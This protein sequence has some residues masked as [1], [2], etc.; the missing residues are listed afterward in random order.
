[1][2]E[3]VIAMAIAAVVISMIMFFISV[4]AKSFRRT[5]DDVNLQMEAQTTINQISNLAMEAKAVDIWNGT[6]D[7]RYTFQYNDTEFKTI[8]LVSDEKKLYQVSTTGFEDAKTVS[9]NMQQNF[10]AE[11]V[12]SLVLTSENKSVTIDLSLSLGEDQYQISKT[13]KMR[14]AK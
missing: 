3:L 13:I 9:Y 6:D 14:N 11:Y 5:S 4:A 8:I 7:I 2:I 12:Q 10:L 1:M